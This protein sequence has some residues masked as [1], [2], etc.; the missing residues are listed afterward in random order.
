MSLHS[1]LAH[2]RLDRQTRHSVVH[3]TTTFTINPTARYNHLNKVA[4]EILNNTV[5]TVELPESEKRDLGFGAVVTRG[6][7]QRLLNH[8]GSFNVKRT[9]LPLFTSLN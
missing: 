3:L 1:S 2:A 7:R 8:D 5:E 6:S 9:G 4:E